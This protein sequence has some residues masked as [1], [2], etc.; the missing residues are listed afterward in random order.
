MG[1]LMVCKSMFQ[2]EGRKKN[3]FPFYVTLTVSSLGKDKTT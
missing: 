2:N 1:S 3:S